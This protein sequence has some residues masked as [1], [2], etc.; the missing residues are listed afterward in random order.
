[1]G[2]CEVA[3]DVDMIV[4]LVASLCVAGVADATVSPETIPDISDIPA[5]SP[6]STPAW[7][8]DL[9]RHWTFPCPLAKILSTQKGN[10]P[11]LKY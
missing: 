6:R 10:A 2:M 11:V 8:I 9:G 4:L 3:L 5:S 1:M 7:R